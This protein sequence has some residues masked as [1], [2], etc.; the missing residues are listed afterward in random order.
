MSKA[1]QDSYIISYTCNVV[2]YRCTAEE[3]SSSAEFFRIKLTL[4]L[5][6]SSASLQFVCVHR[7]IAFVLNCLI[8]MN[9]WQKGAVELCVAQLLLAEISKSTP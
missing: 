2:E 5:I 3:I 7:Y 6:T 8:S 9:C 1:I 4:Y